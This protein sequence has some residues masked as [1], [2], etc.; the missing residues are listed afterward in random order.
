MSNNRQ[1]IS[2][3]RIMWV[4]FRAQNGIVTQADKRLLA[5]YGMDYRGQ[6][7][8]KAFRYWAGDMEK[9]KQHIASIKQER[10]SKA[11]EVRFFTDKQYA[12]AKEETGYEI[13]FTTKQEKEMFI[14]G[15]NK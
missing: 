9:L 12:L 2:G 11:Y 4:E 1:E 5:R 8:C 6:R 13:P 10:L 15:K 14:I 3:Y 7:G